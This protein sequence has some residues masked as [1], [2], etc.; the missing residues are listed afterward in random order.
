MCVRYAAPGTY[1]RPEMDV[2]ANGCPPTSN[3]PAEP[4]GTLNTYLTPASPRK[5]QS[6]YPG[7]KSSQKSQKR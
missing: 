4:Q 2:S 6:R 1:Y 3:F 7:P 5:R